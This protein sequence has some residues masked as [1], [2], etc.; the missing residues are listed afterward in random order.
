MKKIL[1]PLIASVIIINAVVGVAILSSSSAS[2]TKLA[3]ACAENSVL[4]WASS[5]AGGTA[6]TFYYEL[7]LSNVSPHT[8]TLVGFPSVWAVDGG[9][10]PVGLLASHDG[11]PVIVTLAPGGTAHI[12]LG[13]TDP[14]IICP[15]TAQSETTNELEVVPP[16][17]APG[18]W[19]EWNTIM[20]FPLVTC[21]KVVGMHVSAVEAGVGI[22]L[23]SA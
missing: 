14:G 13:V 3:P 19:R 20:N 8:C 1:F 11:K 2:A 4:P 10:V 15:T 23:Y 6:G 18:P 9:G 5:D 7:E 12:L 17:Y 22:P 16:G 21:T